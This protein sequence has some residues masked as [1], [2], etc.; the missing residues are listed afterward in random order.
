[1]AFSSLWLIAS[2]MPSDPFSYPG[3]RPFLSSASMTSAQLESSPAAL[4]AW[5]VYVKCNKIQTSKQGTEVMACSF[6]PFNRVDLILSRA[7]EIGGVFILIEH[8]KN[9]IEIFV[10]LGCLN[11]KR[12]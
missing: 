8:A 12:H 1:M 2:K 11:S 4:N 9:V 7:A 10:L 5:V 6:A 3:M